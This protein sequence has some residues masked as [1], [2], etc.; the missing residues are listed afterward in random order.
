MK[1]APPKGAR[2]IFKE[3]TVTCMFSILPHNIFQ[4][5]SSVFNPA[6]FIYPSN[7]SGTSN[8]LPLYLGFPIPAFPTVLPPVD[9]WKSVKLFASLFRHRCAQYAHPHARLMKQ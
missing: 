9:H 6:L 4:S 1:D 8:R 7:Y 3:I 5:Q 2:V